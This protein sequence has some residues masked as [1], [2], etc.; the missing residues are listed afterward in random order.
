MR[1]CHATKARTAVNTTLVGIGVPSTLVKHPR[2]GEAA[3]AFE[4][5][6]ERSIK[7]GPERELVIGE[8]LLVHARDGI[9][10]PASKRVSEEHYSP[11]GRLF[12][13]RYCTTRQ[14]FNLPGELPES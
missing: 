3:A 4:C 6:I 12:G 9:V 11:V 13:N 7:F 10:D 5:K 2:I 1:S 14:R 8:I